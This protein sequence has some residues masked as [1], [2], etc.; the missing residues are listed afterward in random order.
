M[1]EKKE[2][3]IVGAGLSGICM[4]IHLIKNNHSVTLLDSGENFSTAV[5]AGQINPLVFRRMTKSWRVDDYLPY[6]E[7]FYTDLEIDTELPIYFPIQIRRMFSSAHEKVMWVEKQNRE[8]FSDYLETITSEDDEYD[9]AQN[10]F[11]SGRIKKSS[12]VNALNFVEG[13]KNWIKKR[14]TILTEKLDYSLIEPSSSSY[15]GKKYDFILF[16]EGSH[17]SDNPWFNQFVVE[18][19]KGEVLTLK[20]DEI[21]EHESLNRKCFLLPIGNKT[22]RLGATYVWNTPDRTLTQEAKDDLLDK[23]KLLTKK[24][25]EVVDH[26]VGIRPTTPD[27]RP[28]I[29]KHPTF[30]NLLIFNGL[31]TKGYLMAPLLAKEFV[32]YLDFDK[33]LDKEVRIER[34]IK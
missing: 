18:H 26:Q 31:G 8:G 14:A 22:F 13:G 33:E 28:I 12:Y 6:A 2:Y 27:R 32:D 3:L 25:F 19:T 7:K 4:S 24:S 11:G 15:K 17:N 16:C 29:G 21:S 20:S 5:A 1:T 10:D 30:N 23:V 9:L 34:F